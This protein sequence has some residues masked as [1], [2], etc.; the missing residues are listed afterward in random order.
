MLQGDS[1]N[2]AILDCV[3]S[4]QA[5]FMGLKLELLRMKRYQEPVVLI[6]TDQ[7]QARYI[8]SLIHDS[9]DDNLN[10]IVLC[11]TASESHYGYLGVSLP[12]YDTIVIES[13]GQLQELPDPN[14]LLK[15]NQMEE[16]KP[17]FNKACICNVY[18][19]LKSTKSAYSETTSF[20]EM[21]LQYL[22]VISFDSKPVHPFN[23]VVSFNL[24]PSSIDP[25]SLVATEPLNLQLKRLK[26][27]HALSGQSL[28]GKSNVCGRIDS[29]INCK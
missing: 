13:L 5:E 23:V 3:A 27:L 12:S 6:R 4:S 29:F 18:D 22:G 8:M 17:H 20:I 24:R 7:D 25:E 1:I 26:K 16:Y 15:S 11:L 14:D 19:I 21:S 9:P 2:S 10:I 28:Q